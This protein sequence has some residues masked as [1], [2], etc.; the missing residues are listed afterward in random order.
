MKKGD[1]VTLK[2]YCKDSGRTAIITEVPPYLRC[3]KIMYLDTFETVAALNINLILLSKG[4]ENI[5]EI[6]S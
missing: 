5:D 3:V 1:L 4:N 2:E 6:H